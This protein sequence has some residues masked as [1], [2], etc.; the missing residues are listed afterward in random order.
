MKIPSRRPS[1]ALGGPRP[2]PRTAARSG[3]PRGRGRRPYRFFFVFAV[4]EE[5]RGRHVDVE[6]FR[7]RVARDREPARGDA[8]GAA[9]RGGAI[10]VPRAERRRRA[11][12]EVGSL[13]R[14]RERRERRERRQDEEER[15]E[16]PSLVVIAPL[17]RRHRRRRRRRRRSRDAGRAEPEARLLRSP[18][19]SRLARLDDLPA[20]GSSLARRAPASAARR[21]RARR[22]RRERDGRCVAAAVLER[23]RLAR[24]LPTARDPTARRR[25]SSTRVRSRR[26]H[27][28]RRATADRASRPRLARASCAHRR[29]RAARRRCRRGGTRTTSPAGTARARAPPTPRERR[30]RTTRRRR[31]RARWGPCPGGTLPRAYPTST[32][33]T[34]R[35]SSRRIRRVIL[36]PVPIRPRS[37]GARRSL[38]TFPGVS[39]RP[40][41]LAFDPRARRLS[42]PTDAFERHPDVASRGTRLRFVEATRAR[43]RRPA[44]AR[45]P[46]AGAAR[47]T[48]SARDG[49]TAPPPRGRAKAKA[50]GRRRPRRRRR[51]RAGRRDTAPRTRGE[52]AAAEVRLL[53]IRPRSR[54]AR[55]VRLTDRFTHAGGAGRGKRDAKPSSKDTVTVSRNFVAFVCAGLAFF[56]FTTVMGGHHNRAFERHFQEMSKVKADR[57]ALREENEWLRREN[58]RLRG[59]SGG[60][61]FN[62]PPPPPQQQQQREVVVSPPLPPPQPG[63]GFRG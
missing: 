7:V 39:L 57:R 14:G 48:R 37:R 30:R 28:R 20:R 21:S 63:G 24:A 40:G 2:G 16:R 33:R 9:V 19:A 29:S 60:G 36:T 8:V 61:R 15:R 54:G 55:H 27:R 43:R 10:A 53:P 56:G 59:L 32:P 25:A 4:A 38:R 1:P 52:A 44:A 5:I 6:L 22:T 18:R 34:A 51:R 58:Q 26:A 50:A 11:R 41:P 47:K 13:E 49:G 35:A 12:L 42:T 31:R 46:A 45:G 62:A 17:R 3:P 23:P